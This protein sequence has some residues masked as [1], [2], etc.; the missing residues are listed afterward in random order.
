MLVGAAQASK[1]RREDYEVDTVDY[2]A[3]AS[4]LELNQ[5]AQDWLAQF[6]ILNESDE[7]LMAELDADAELELEKDEAKAA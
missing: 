1:A 7:A 3:Q 2:L 5:D 6:D 4:E